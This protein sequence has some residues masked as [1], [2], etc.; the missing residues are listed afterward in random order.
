MP[1]PGIKNERLDPWWCSLD[2]VWN[3]NDSYWCVCW[4]WQVRCRQ[5]CVKPSH[6]SPPHITSSRSP[7]NA[8]EWCAPSVVF[9]GQ[10]DFSPLPIFLS[11]S[12]LWSLHWMKLWQPERRDK[13]SLWRPSQI[14]WTIPFAIIKDS[15]QE[16]KTDFLREAFESHMIT[17]YRSCLSYL[18][19]SLKSKH[20]R[21][22]SFS[23]WSL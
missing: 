14:R 6:P 2:V 7:E 13:P 11:S 20:L 19:A 9:P 15:S 16:T 10:L 3:N 5:V 18:V 1:N 17:L 12:N 22:V 21:A 8:S 23:S 4:Q